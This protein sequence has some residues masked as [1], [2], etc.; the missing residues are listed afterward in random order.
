MAEDEEDCRFPLYEDVLDKE[1]FDGAPFEEG[2]YIFPIRS[3]F[4]SFP[5]SGNSKIIKITNDVG[6][7]DWRRTL[8][9]EVFRF[10]PGIMNEDSTVKN[11]SIEEY[12]AAQ[13]EH[14]ADSAT[15]SWLRNP[16]RVLYFTMTFVN[17]SLGMA[18]EVN[19][20]I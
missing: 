20:V 2:S 15:S 17:E 6:Q 19:L 16:T 1:V 8:Q 3:R 5:G 12:A 10:P 4:T 18:T 9:E 11:L 13:A 14:L 7:I